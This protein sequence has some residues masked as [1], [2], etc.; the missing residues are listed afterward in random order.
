MQCRNLCTL[1]KEE[2]VVAEGVEKDVET[3]GEEED[4][5]ALR[6]GAAGAA[7]TATT[8]TTVG[9]KTV[10]ITTN[11]HEEVIKKAETAMNAEKQDTSTET[12]QS[13]EMGAET[14]TEVDPIAMAMEVDLVSYPVARDGGGGVFGLLVVPGL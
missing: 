5:E 13:D 7:P 14:E 3:I 2:E 6:G 1:S 12:V 8:S 9:R 10:T 11:G 4:T